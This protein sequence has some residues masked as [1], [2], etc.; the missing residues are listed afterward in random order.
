MKTLEE[1]IEGLH[2]YKLT[3]VAKHANIEYMQV[4]KIYTGRYDRPPYHLVKKLSDWLED[5][6]ND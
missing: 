2:R 1:V 5:R 6:A 3:V 4:Y